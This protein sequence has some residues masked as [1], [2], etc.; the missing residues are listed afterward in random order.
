MKNNEQISDEYR[1]LAEQLLLQHD[2][3][4]NPTIK[5]YQ[6]ILENGLPVHPN[7]AKKKILIIGAGIAGLLAAK[8]LKDQGHTV[9]ILEANGNRVGGRIKTF[10]TGFKNEKQYAEAGAMRIPKDHPLINTFLEKYN[11]E[12]RE[13]YNVDVDPHSGEKV[14]RGWIYCNGGTRINQQEYSQSP[15]K[16]NDTFKVSCDKPAS[17]ILDEA[18]DRARDYYSSKPENGERR[19]LPYPQWLAGWAKLIE[20]YD[21]Y[22]LRRFL[23]EE[24]EL[25]DNEMALVGTI[26]NLT[27]RQPL[28]F[29]HS[30]LGRSSINPD[31]KYLEVIGGSWKL[32]E[33]L[34]AELADCIKCNHRVTH[35]NFHKEDQLNSDHAAKGIYPVSVRTVGEKN[36]GSDADYTDIHADLAIVTIPFSS[37]RF[38][39]INPPLPLKKRRAVTE[40]HYDSATKVLL[41]FSKRWW[42]FDAEQWQHELTVLKNNGEMGEKQYKHYM[43][44]LIDLPPRN[45]VGGSSITDHANRFSYFP[46]HRIEDSEGGV[47]LS[48]YTWADDARRWDSMDDEQ[49]YEFSLKELA[50]VHG[51]RI[52]A[53]YTGN[54]YAKTQSWARNPYAFGEAAVFAPGQLTSLHPSIPTSYGP[55]HFAGEHTSLKHAWIEGSLESAIRVALEIDAITT[56]SH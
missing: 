36:F 27:S 35:I 21:E 4:G 34:E 52:R 31:Q 50:L 1:Q 10:R 26:V 42:E 45:S 6:A 25:N 3:E 11:I 16:I 28:A 19:D 37:L 15:K 49:R 33:K 55:L 39:Q 8:L 41:E 7:G 2:V 5:H 29:M 14:G 51:E 30:F 12:T 24:G 53:F 32:I 20:K 43:Q 9:E 17:V 13:F 47:V 44:E 18:L 48:S 40:L 54:Q 23:K 56:A 46:S 22:S 38:V